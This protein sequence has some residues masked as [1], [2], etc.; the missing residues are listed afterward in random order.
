MNMYKNHNYV[1]CI[2]LGKPAEF[3][4]SKADGFYKDPTDCS[5][6]YQCSF[7]VS[8]HETCPSGTYFSDALQGC[9][10]AANVPSCP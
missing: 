5:R 1:Y 9:D 4:K 6:F 8:Y 10:W 7:H 3:C 2:F